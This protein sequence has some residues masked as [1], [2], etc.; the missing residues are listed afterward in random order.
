VGASEADHFADVVDEQEARLDLVTVLLA[1]DGH[2]DWQFHDSSSGIRRLA[3]GAC[4]RVR[5]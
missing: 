2:L 5:G 4:Q 1:I 3:W